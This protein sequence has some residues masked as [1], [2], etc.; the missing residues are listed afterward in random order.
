MRT[1][2]EYSRP[3][4]PA[5]A[6]RRAAAGPGRVARKG[7]TLVEMVAATVLLMVVMSVSVQVLGWAAGQRRTAERRQWATQE[8]ANIME[9]LASEPWE[10][11]TAE[12][13]Q[14]IH[15]SKQ[16]GDVLPGGELHVELADQPGPPAA[17]RL[18][19][20][21]RWRNRAGEFDTPVRLT[22]WVYRR[23]GGA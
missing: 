15:L 17:K 3:V 7:A 12:T 23:K 20:E 16:A 2:T 13:V 22:N 6:R 9:R 19:L 5:T 14:A 4:W 10:N 11:L 18:Q 21:L 8:L 1:K